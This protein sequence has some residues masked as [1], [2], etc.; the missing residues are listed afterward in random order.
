VTSPNTT[1]I[2]NVEGKSLWTK[3]LS[4]YFPGFYNLY[5]SQGLNIHYCDLCA[6]I[7]IGARNGKLYCLDCA[8]FAQP[9]KMRVVPITEFVYGITYFM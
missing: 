8:V 7:L 4:H 3:V 2:L 1:K 5:L 9:L 6:V